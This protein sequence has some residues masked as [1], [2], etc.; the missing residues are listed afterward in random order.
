MCLLQSTG[1]LAEPVAGLQEAKAR[2][3]IATLKAELDTL[4]TLVETAADRANEELVA[5][6]ILE[7]EDLMQQRDAQVLL[8]AVR[9]F[10]V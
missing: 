6:L 9:G 2:E 7:K 8:Q 3:T 10:V 1:S 4:S 5:K